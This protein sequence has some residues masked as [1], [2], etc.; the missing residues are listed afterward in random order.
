[1]Q[2]RQIEEEDVTN[3]YA[4]EQSLKWSTGS[5]FTCRF[6]SKGS[7]LLQ[8][9]INCTF[10]TLVC[11]VRQTHTWCPSA[12]VKK[13]YGIKVSNLYATWPVLEAQYSGPHIHDQEKQNSISD[14]SFTSIMP[15]PCF[16]YRKQADSLWGPA[17]PWSIV[18]GFFKAI[19]CGSVTWN[20]QVT[21][22]CVESSLIPN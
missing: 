6:I 15:K 11:Y 19:R 1:M 17:M 9:F 13:V 16:V 12:T 10:Y 7:V 14:L 22:L 5:R 4:R 2:A 3:T 18:A 21:F 8:T 20:M